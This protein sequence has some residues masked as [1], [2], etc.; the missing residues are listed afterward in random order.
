MSGL[1]QRY[2][3][4]IMDRNTGEYNYSIIAAIN[5]SDMRF[6]KEI[7][8]LAKEA[9][10]YYFWGYVCIEDMTITDVIAEIA[11]FK[12]FCY[13]CENSII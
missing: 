4:M 13:A 12:K 2:L 5:D 6:E 10:G 11:A 3:C 7:D 1:M 8:R 9:N